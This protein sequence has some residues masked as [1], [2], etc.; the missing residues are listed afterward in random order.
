MKQESGFGECFQFGARRAPWGKATWGRP[1]NSDKPGWWGDWFGDPPPRAERGGVRYLVL[2][3]I[4]CRPRHG[5]EVISAIEE[6]SKG[7]YRPSP[8]VI[9]PTLQML[10]ELQHARAVEIEGRRVYEITDAG[11]AELE[12][13]RAEVDDFY[14]RLLEDSWESHMENFG[15]VMRRLGHLFRAFRRAARR[16]HLSA[17]TLSRIRE[18]IDEAIHK[19]EQLLEREP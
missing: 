14:D 13:H 16:G 2:D 3:A 7:G 15:E 8:G 17:T 9:Y 10:D 6:R 18:I 1:P 11:R 19:L 4:S 12:V 5:Y